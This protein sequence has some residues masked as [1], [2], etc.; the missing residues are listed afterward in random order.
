MMQNEMEAAV[1]CSGLFLSYSV[2]LEGGC[3]SHEGRICESDVDLRRLHTM[4]ASRTTLTGEG[5]FSGFAVST[6]TQRERDFPQCGRRLPLRTLFL[7]SRGGLTQD[8]LES[9]L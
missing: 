9:S 1:G 4:I 6:P 5:S 2:I 3:A 7:R 8:I